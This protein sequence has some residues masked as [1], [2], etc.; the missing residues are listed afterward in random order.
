[1][2]STR[3]LSR[4]T[5]AARRR[6]VKMCVW[7]EVSRSGFYEWR[8]RAS[9]TARRRNEL[10]LYVVK[11]FDESEESYG[12]R[13][14]HA[15]LI[16]WGVEAGP[17]LVRS[18]M[19]E[20]GL[21]PCQPPAVAVQPDRERRPG[22]GHPR[23]RAAG[24]HRRGAWAENGWRHHLRSDVGRLGLSDGCEIRILWKVWRQSYDAELGPRS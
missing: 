8:G 12:Y 2:H 18:I 1:M 17:E 9:A 22:P 21:V 7:L 19:R 4:R 24:F 15:D 10:A 14:V 20:L 13:R 11:S 23:P 3:T 5:R 6:C 16:E